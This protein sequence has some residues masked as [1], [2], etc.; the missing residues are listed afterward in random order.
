MTALSGIRVIDLAD[1]A[2]A[3]C[4]KLLAD[5]GA[6]V[7]LVEPPESSSMRRLGPFYRNQ[8]DP[9]R[10]LFFWHYNTNKRSIVLDP[11]TPADRRSLYDLVMSADVA[12]TTGTPSQLR[13]RGFDYAEL[14]SRNH[15]LVVAAITP[16]GLSGPRCEW[17]SCDTVAQ[18]TGGM[19]FLNGHPGEPPLCS[20]GSQAYHAASLHAAIGVVLALL[21]REHIGRGQLVEIS[22]Q[23][24]AA[25]MV[26]HANPH[27]R[28]TGEVE[29]RRGTLHWSRYFR[30]TR[31]RDGYAVQSTLGDW[32]S[33]LEWLKAEGE[34]QD[35]VAPAWES[36][37]YRRL[38]HARVFD[39]LDQWTLGHSVSELIEGAQLRG[40]PFAPVTPLREL[41]RNEQLKS[42]GFFVQVRHGEL[43]ETLAY[44]G[45]PY[46]LSR[47]PWRLQ[48]R[49]PLLGEHS[50]E[51]LRSVQGLRSRSENESVLAVIESPPPQS[52]PIEG[53]ELRSLPPLGGKVWMGA[54]A[55]GMQGSADSVGAQQVLRGVRV[56]DFTW[57][58]AGPVATRVLADFG[59][60]VIKVERRDSPDSGDR[61]AG[62]IGNLN[63]GKRSIVVNM[64][65]PRGLSL[66][67]DLIA[68]SHLVVDNFSSRVMRNWGLDYEALRSIK[69]DIIAL[70]MSGFGQTGP[71]AD[72]VSYAPTL[73]ALAG[74]TFHMRIAGQPPAGWG[75]S[76]SD[77][78]AGY[79]GA[80]AALLALFHRERTGEG[81]FIDLSQLEALAA[82]IGPDLLDVLVNGADPEPRGNRSPGAAPH[83]IY[84]CCPGSSRG[85]DQDRWCAIC[86]FSDQEWD[87]LVQVM[88]SPSWAKDGRFST[89]EG[90]LAYQHELDV[91]V[92]EWTRQH[93]S[94]ALAE[95]LQASRIAAGPVAS[96]RDL[97]EHDE[98]LRRR[99][100]WIEVQSQGGDSWLFD[101]NPIRLTA[102][103][104]RVETPGPL[105]GEH[106]DEVLGE[107]L[108]LR[109]STIGTLR[110]EGVIG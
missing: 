14:S 55:R 36:L 60:D 26:E 75:F 101:G 59:A 47:T 33:L 71:H 35:L 95:R 92:S 15:A 89:M 22:L 96:A 84:P 98:H 21:A 23:E 44:P 62:V 69:P 63:R 68:R 78:V 52:S 37:E 108:G 10:S 86:V 11:Q 43:E 29:A 17:K 53:E 7:I 102:A 54:H 80:L 61:R 87:H 8:P 25:A 50:E 30:M 19:A 93:D 73:H 3:Y 20:L 109:R 82:V 100:Y 90:R 105:L 110:S 57:V 34:A 88:G 6:D 64:S 104:S 65:D 77:M 85:L 83:G 41:P 74:Y 16:F 70:S 76:F 48:R 4:G 72:Y 9:E 81:Q 99:G 38:N 27:Y 79:S 45:A 39:V 51:I 106:T 97:C 46:R 18:A 91:K 1:E 32:T 12:I 49:A 2:G 94:H 58:F 40:L 66:V 103:P 107:T 13:R 28:T 42:R 31:C 24:S 5:M 56:I 67:R